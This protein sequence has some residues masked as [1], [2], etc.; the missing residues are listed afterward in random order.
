M[1]KAMKLLLLAA[2]LSISVCAGSAAAQ[3][4]L[5]VGTETNGVPFNFLNP[6]SQRMQGFMIDLVEA[7]GKQAGFSSSI[8]P[9]DFSALIPA[10]T[11]NKIDIIASSMYITDKRRQVI[12]F[13]QSVYTYGEGMVVPASD[14]KDY[15]SYQELKGAVIGAQVG[16]VYGDSLKSAGIF[17]EVKVYETIPGIIQDVNAGRTQAGIADYPTL[18]YYLAQGQFPGTR[19]VKTYKVSLPGSIG[20]GLRKGDPALKQKLE[21]ALAQL[22][23]NGEL[24]A[25]LKKWNLD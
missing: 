21:T 1:K 18:A 13:T 4:T 25:M 16:T 22:K 24:A 15:V 2:S 23:A 9:M 3:T 8:E 7:V 6:G 11:A 20:L 14:K 10:L 17:K 19:L 5:R 12:D